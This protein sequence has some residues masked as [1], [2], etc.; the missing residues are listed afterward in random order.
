LDSHAEPVVMP[1]R[2]LPAAATIT[3]SFSTAAYFSAAPSAAWSRLLF[4]G[5]HVTAEMLMTRAPRSAAR[6]MARAMLATST[7]AL[8]STGSPPGSRGEYFADVCRCHPGEAV[9]ARL[10]GDEAGDKG[11][12]AVA[13]GEAVGRFDKVATGL[14]VG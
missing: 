1:P 2:L 10:A 13:V 7:A 8:D 12:V 6:T 3:A 14:D 4:A 11:A 9:V 5:R